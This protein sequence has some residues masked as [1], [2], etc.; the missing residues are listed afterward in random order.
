[1]RAEFLA[2]ISHELRTPLTPIKGFASL[3]QS[4][5]LTQAKARGFADEIAT[6]ADE[7]ERVITQLV[8]FATIA[9][10][11]LS[12]DPR[13]VPLRPLVD[14][15]LR[16]WRERVDGTHRLVRRVPAGV[17]QVVADPTYLT[18][19]LEELVDNAV[20]YSPDGGTVV[21]EAKVIDGEDGPALELSVSDEGIGIP[22]DQLDEIMGDFAQGDASTT[23]QFGGLGLGLALVQRIAHAHGG[24]LVVDS[25]P[26]SGSR[27]AVVLPLDGLDGGRS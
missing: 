11:Q 13:P 8:N 17:P 18:Q 5:K 16:T 9:D 23:R 27:V 1:M 3:L 4:R 22:A 12:L 24:S 7:L 19:L 20:K 25:E 6:A 10:G 14:N 26:G 21:V 15:V 2:N